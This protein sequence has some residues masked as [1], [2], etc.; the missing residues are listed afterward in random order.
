M[1]ITPACRD[2]GGSGLFYQMKD[3][4][5]HCVETD[6]ERIEREARE[7]FIKRDPK[8]NQGG[9]NKNMGKPR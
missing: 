4:P 1:A 5:C 3:T 6:T 2:C 8:K 7:E 9:K